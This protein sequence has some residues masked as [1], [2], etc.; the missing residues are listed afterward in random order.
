MFMLTRKVMGSLYKL[1]FASARNFVLYGG[2]F[3]LDPAKVPRS[4]H[5]IP[6]TIDEGGLGA[7]FF[8]PILRKRARE[9]AGSAT[10]LFPAYFGQNDERYCVD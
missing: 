4:E 2:Y 7:C 10:M 1:L 9:E 6:D 8:G 5:K 3:G